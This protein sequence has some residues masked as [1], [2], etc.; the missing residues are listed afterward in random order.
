MRTQDLTNTSNFAKLSLRDAFYLEIWGGATFDVA[1]HFLHEC[2]WKLLVTLKEK[3]PYVR[4]R[5]CCA[6]PT[7]WN[8]P[9][10]PIT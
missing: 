7:P 6:A 2:T 8:I 4:F 9:T 5:F 10:T 3:V 1:M